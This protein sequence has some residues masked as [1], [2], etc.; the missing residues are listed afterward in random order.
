[1]KNW[2]L[3]LMF[4]I[5]LCYIILSLQSS[6]QGNNGMG[7]HSDWFLIIPCLWL[8]ADNNKDINF[9]NSFLNPYLFGNRYCC[10]MCCKTLGSNEFLRITKNHWSKENSLVSQD[11]FEFILLKTWKQSYEIDSKA[12]ILLCFWTSG[13]S[14]RPM[15]WGLP[16][17][18]WARPQATLRGN[19]RKIIG[20][21]D[22]PS[23]FNCLPSK[24]VTAKTW[25]LEI[26]VAALNI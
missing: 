20:N 15:G 13:L 22:H 2:V 11:A 3:F 25:Q 1:M 10:K 21:K 8:H 12:K 14:L 6:P 24:N 5:I 18:L 26:L 4:F 17:L 19:K 16:W 7:S 9:I 23:C